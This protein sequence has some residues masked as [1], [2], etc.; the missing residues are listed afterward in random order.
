MTD[1]LLIDGNSIG[2]AAQQG[3][4][5]TLGS[6]EVQAIFGV[7]RS[8]R[9]LTAQFP[10]LQ[11]LVLWDGRSWR[12]QVFAEYKA[13]RDD[14]AN[15]KV[16]AMRDSYRAQRPHISRGLRHLGIWQMIAGN[17]EAD[18]LAGMMVKKAMRDS[19]AALM[20]SGDKDWLQLVGNRIVWFDPI[21]QNRVSIA[22]FKEKTGYANPRAFLE[23]KA[24]Q[25]D[26]GDNIPGVGGIGEK[27]AAQ[28]LEKFASVAA[29]LDWVGNDETKELGKK[30]REF[31]FNTTGGLDKFARNMQLMDLIPAS[32]PV[33]E[34]LSLTRGAVDVAVFTE[35]CEEFQFHSMLND[36]TGW[37]A[38]F[39]RFKEAA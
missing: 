39:E 18:D 12:K 8:V 21:R 27:G 6:T 29:F 10:T 17:M 37:M 3:T 9:M 24:L 20:V 14:K 5:L 1:Y 16:L 31:A 28:L 19:S 38:P 25:G 30:L 35:F 26:A 4:R 7:L 33:P 22:N 36:L 34:R 15:P 13:N 23:G 2:F 32:P 11:P